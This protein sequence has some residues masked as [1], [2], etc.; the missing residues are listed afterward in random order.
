MRATLNI[1]I[2]SCAVLGGFAVGRAQQVSPEESRRWTK[3]VPPEVMQKWLTAMPRGSTPEDALKRSLR[4]PEIVNSLRVEE[5]IRQHSLPTSVQIDDV[6]QALSRQSCIGDLAHWAR[7]YSYAVDYAH[8][9][10]NDDAVWFDLREAG[11]FGFQSERKIGK[12]RDF[13][14]IDDRQF[15]IATGTY[16]LKSHRL[17]MDS[18]GQNRS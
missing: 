15:L 5:D 10:V 3:E 7:R 11:R 12:P 4:S 18:C 1:V 2:L 8:G 16:D 14:E 9:R 13:A 6:E 17:T